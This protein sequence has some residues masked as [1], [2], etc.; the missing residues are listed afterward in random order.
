MTYQTPELFLVGAAQGLV[1]GT[2]MLDID[3]RDN[4]ETVGNTQVSRHTQ[5]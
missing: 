3:F 1:L 2:N 4:P 5:R